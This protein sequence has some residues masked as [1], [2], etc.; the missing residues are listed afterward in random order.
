MILGLIIGFGVGI[1]AGLWIGSSLV[2]NLTKPLI[3]D[4]R[5]NVDYW[6][7]SYMESRAAYIKMF[8]MYVKELTK[9]VGK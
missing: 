5:K 7:K 3:E 1:N 9:N 6:F 8:D 2:R 4:Y